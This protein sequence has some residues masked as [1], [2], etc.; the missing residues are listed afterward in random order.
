MALT[1]TVLLMLLKKPFVHHLTKCLIHNSVEYRASCLEGKVNSWLSLSKIMGKFT[2]APIC[3]Q[4]RCQSWTHHTGLAM[5]KTATH[6]RTFWHS[7]VPFT[8]VP[9][10]S[11]DSWLSISVSGQHCLDPDAYMLDVYR[12]NPQAEW[13]IKP[14]ASWSRRLWRTGQKPNG[15]EWRLSF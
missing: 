4:A 1:A 12:A 5:C 11:Y 6:P 9:R 3:I 7:S 2:K 14:K 13:V 15:W 10:T 8:N